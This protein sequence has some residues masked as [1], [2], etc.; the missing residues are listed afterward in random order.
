MTVTSGAPSPTPRR[1]RRRARTLGVGLLSGALALSGVG[2]A[3][4]AQAAVSIDATVLINEVYGGGGNGGAAFSRDF[5]ELV[6]TG[7]TAVDLGSW[8]VQYASAT[9]TSWQVTPLTG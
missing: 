3:L 2:L 7:D 9:G 1:S 6:N 4:P 5:V 8:S